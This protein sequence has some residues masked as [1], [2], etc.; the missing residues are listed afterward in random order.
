MLVDIHWSDINFKIHAMFSRNNVHKP[1]EIN[2][3]LPAEENIKSYQGDE[4][5]LFTGAL[6]T[7]TYY[8]PLS[9]FFY[10]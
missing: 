7:T 6:L 5:D 2:N 8:V 4:E 9:S 1:Y 3:A 10:S